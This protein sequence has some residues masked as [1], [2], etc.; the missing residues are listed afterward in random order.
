MLPAATLRPWRSLESIATKYQRRT[1]ESTKRMSTLST[2]NLA[3][4]TSSAKALINAQRQCVWFC[5][6]SAK[7]IA[8]PG[9]AWV[10]CS[11]TQQLIKPML[12]KTRDSY[13]VDMISQAL[14]LAA[15]TD[16]DYAAET[17][18]QV[19]EQRQVLQQALNTMGFTSP[20]SEANFLLATTPDEIDAEGLYEALKAKGILVR[21]FPTQRLKDK[22]RI[23]V[24]TVEQNEKLISTIRKLITR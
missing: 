10:I 24:G 13:N 3:Y 15:I 19:R 2:Q 20:A 8:W 5:A 22:L 16:Q 1:V 21:Y 17:W 9:C 12:E 23:T 6:P 7:A 11:A 14:G 18:R 4:S